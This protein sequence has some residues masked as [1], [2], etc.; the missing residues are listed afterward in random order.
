MTAPL[1]SMRDVSTLLGHI[2]KDAKRSFIHQVVNNYRYCGLV[3]EFDYV[4]SKITKI[5]IRIR[6]NEK[7]HVSSDSIAQRR[8]FFVN[9]GASRSPGYSFSQTRV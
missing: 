9:D 2:C 8:A 6:I 3:V 7:S 1:V 4:I 5:I